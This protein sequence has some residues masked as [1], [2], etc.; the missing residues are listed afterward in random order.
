MTTQIYNKKVHNK[1]L[2]LWNPANYGEYIEKLQKLMLEKYKICKVCDDIKLHCEY[3][4]NSQTCKLCS[5][6]IKDF[7]KTLKH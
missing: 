1:V 6:Q 3:K 4:N 7:K 5:N 2:R